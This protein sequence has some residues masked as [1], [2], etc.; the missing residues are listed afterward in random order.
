MS[1]VR[2]IFHIEEKIELNGSLKLF[3]EIKKFDK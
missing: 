3:K 2:I 1:T